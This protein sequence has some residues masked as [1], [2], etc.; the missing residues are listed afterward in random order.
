MIPATTPRC[1][2]RRWRH[3]L[4][5]AAGANWRSG[6]RRARRSAPGIAFFVEKSGLGPRDG[7]TVAV[8]PA[9]AVELVT[10]GAS[11]G[12]GFE[13]VMA[14]ICAD[15]LGCDYRDVRVIH[16]QTDRIAQRHRRACLARH[17]DDGIGD[18]DRRGEA[19][20]AWPSRRRRS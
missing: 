8:D 19:A 2:T 18:G 6:A 4:G 16:G 20:R 14:Q 12:Q 17:G 15:A 3:R 10:G 13:T 11:L 7:V 5:G 1:S 9:G